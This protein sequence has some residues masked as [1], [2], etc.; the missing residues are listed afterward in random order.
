MCLGPLSVLGSH[1][2]QTC[3]SPMR[4]AAVPLSLGVRALVQ[5]CLELFISYMSCIPSGSDRRDLMK[6]PHLGLSLSF[7]AHCP[8]KGLC[9]CSHPLHTEAFLMMVEQENDQCV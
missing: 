6:T 4:A 1:L 8:I 2:A 9:I 7:S 3:V 5:M